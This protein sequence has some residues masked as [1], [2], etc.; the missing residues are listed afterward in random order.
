MLYRRSWDVSSSL[1][2]TLYF[3][4]NTF[5]LIFSTKCP[6]TDEWKRKC[7]TYSKIT[8]VKYCSTFRSKGVLSFATIWINLMNL[9]LSEISQ[10]QKTYT[11]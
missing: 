9:T 3:V 7:L 11:I 2:E 8:T 5:T 10:T 1:I 4:I 6:L